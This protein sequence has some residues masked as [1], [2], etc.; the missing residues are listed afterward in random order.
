MRFRIVAIG[1]PSGDLTDAL[2][3]YEERLSRFGAI[4]ILDL[5]PTK[6]RDASEAR[7]KEGEA[8]LA[9]AVDHVITLDERGK[10]RTTERLASHLETLEQRGISRITLLI[11]GAEG[12]D[13]T[14]RDRADESWR[15]SDFTLAH[16]VARLVLLEQLYRVAT[17]RAGHP[18][19]RGG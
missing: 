3:K 10:A 8:L 18:Y 14:V 1:T 5:K 17:L 2:R 4:E 19:H 6:V 13:E 16:D 11:G 15:L 12:L 7:R 9:Q